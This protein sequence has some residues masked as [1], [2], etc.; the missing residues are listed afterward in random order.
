MAQ[1]AWVVLRGSGLPRG[2]G[3]GCVVVA[4][5]VTWTGFG[6]SQLVC[7]CIWTCRG[8]MWL[9]VAG[10]MWL[11]QCY[12][13]W[14]PRM[15]LEA[16]RSCYNLRIIYP[17]LSSLCQGSRKT[18]AR[19]AKKGVGKHYKVKKRATRGGEKTGWKN[20]QSCPRCCIKLLG[21]RRTSRGSWAPNPNG[22]TYSCVMRKNKWHE[23]F[24]GPG[25]C[26]GERSTSRTGCCHLAYFGDVWCKM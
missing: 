12:A 9:H 26:D 7:V 11:W 10:C 20:V 16:R 24:P 17:L 14:K 25:A 4:V 23:Y 18:R 19:S 8:C 5:A 13:R 2:C 22:G 6:V 15:P 21:E 1:S 3:P